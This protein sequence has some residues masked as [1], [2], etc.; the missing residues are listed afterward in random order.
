MLSYAYFFFLP[1]VPSSRGRAR[2]RNASR[3]SAYNVVLAVLQSYSLTSTLDVGSMRSKSPKWIS[4]WKDEGGKS[5]PVLGQ[6]AVG[7]DKIT[8]L[9]YGLNGAVCAC[10]VY[11]CK[12]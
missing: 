6:R 2:S 12:L 5:G 9:L 3:L 1:L 4:V 10:T 7:Q 11:V 8:C